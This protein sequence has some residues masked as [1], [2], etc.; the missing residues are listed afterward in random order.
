MMIWQDASGARL[1]YRNGM[2]HISDLDEDRRTMGLSWS[3]HR[4]TLVRIGLGC[5]WA[6]V[7]ARK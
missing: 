7:W 4:W 2:L 5:L 6:A 3:M 1:S